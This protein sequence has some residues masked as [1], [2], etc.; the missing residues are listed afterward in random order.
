MYKPNSLRERLVAAVPELAQD[1]DKL[2]ILVRSGKLV[3]TGAASLSFEYAFTLQLVVLDFAG[4][5]DAIMVPLLAWLQVHQPEIFDNPTLR[6]K[7]VRFEVDYLNTTAV[8]LS[9][10]LDLTE[11]VIVKPRAGGP[12]GALDV[13][14]AAEPAR[15]GVVLQA[16]HWEVWCKG[17]KLAEWDYAAR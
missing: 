7:S 12:L 6:E 5:A 15:T 14:H 3:C 16:E 13:V 11:R 8:D 17:E 10:E 4:N 9:I 2:S 1:P